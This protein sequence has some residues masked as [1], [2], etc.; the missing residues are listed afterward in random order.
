MSDP[1]GIRNRISDFAALRNS[2]ANRWLSAKRQNYRFVVFA[3]IYAVFV[4]EIVRKVL[5]LISALPR[6][7]V[8]EERIE[9]RIEPNQGGWS[10]RGQTCA[11]IVMLRIL[12]MSVLRGTR[13][14]KISSG[15]AK[16]QPAYV[17]LTTRKTKRAGFSADSFLHQQPS[18]FLKDRYG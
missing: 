3:Q 15:C 1:N 11:M 9:H 12:S 7:R 5:T 6:S 16:N 13:E 2:A 8:L 10:C 17:D 4:S 14:R 18:L